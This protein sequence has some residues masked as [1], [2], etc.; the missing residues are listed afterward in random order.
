MAWWGGLPSVCSHAMSQDVLQM[1][2]RAGYIVFCDLAHEPSTCVLV[3]VHV[4]IPALSEGL[5]SKNL[6]LA[7]YPYED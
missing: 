7:T 3:C 5:S 6:D 4:C 2:T 1:P